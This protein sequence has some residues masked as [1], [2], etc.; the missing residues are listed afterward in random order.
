MALSGIA[1][2]I[3]LQSSSIRND[4]DTL[5]PDNDSP[6]FTVTSGL[7]PCIKGRSLSQ[8]QAAAQAAETRLTAADAKV[9]AAEAKAADAQTL[10][11]NLVAQHY[12]AWMPQWVT[13]GYERVTCP[14]LSLSCSLLPLGLESHSPS[15]QCLAKYRFPS[16]FRYR[17]EDW[18]RMQR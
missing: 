7:L 4:G 9:A 10:A 17:F 5:Q 8:A 11:D 2:G 12:E 15:E 13:D 16:M 18:K 3:C 14:A 1:P 6:M